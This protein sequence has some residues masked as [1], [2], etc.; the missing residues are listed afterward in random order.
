MRSHGVAAPKSVSC[1]A[2]TR[3]PS[4]RR[5][6]WPRCATYALREVAQRIGTGA[7]VGGFVQAMAREI[8]A[9]I[10][11]QHERRKLMLEPEG[12]RA[13]ADAAA[14]RMARDVVDRLDRALARH[15]QPAVAKHGVDEES[16]RGLPAR[17]QRQRL[18]GGAV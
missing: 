9:R 11:R 7:A 5:W 8:E 18:A 10:R 17:I 14:P 16:V 15:A 2:S 13:E 1:G 12:E 6:C 3:R 4:A